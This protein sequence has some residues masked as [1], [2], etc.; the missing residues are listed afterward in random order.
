[1]KSVQMKTKVC[2]VGDSAVG[3]TSLIRR[4]VLNAFDDKYILTVG[5]NVCKKRLEV[6]FSEIDTEVVCDLMIWDIMGQKG[7]RDLLKTAYFYNVEGII[8]VCDVT[9]SSTLFTLNDWIKS[10]H[11]IAGNVPVVLVANKVDLVDD[12][13]FGQEDLSQI[14]KIYDSPYFFSSAKTGENVET[15]FQTLTE[16]VAAEQLKKSEKIVVK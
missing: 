13:Q 5:T 15:V 9:L 1:M 4:F 7:F 12:S 14:A 16:R 3:K 11:S 8:A 2:L 6:H 10:V